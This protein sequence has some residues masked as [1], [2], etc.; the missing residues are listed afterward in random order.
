MPF[1]AMY[2][3]AWQQVWSTWMQMMNPTTYLAPLSGKVSVTAEVRD[4]SSAL[5]ED[6]EEMR[7]ALKEFRRQV[8]DI[9][10]EDITRGSK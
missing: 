1:F 4:R 2:M 5:D 9:W 10:P 7:R 8:Q 3:Q 6:R